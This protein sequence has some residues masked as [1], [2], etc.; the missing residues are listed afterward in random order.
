MKDLY[1]F[2]TSVEDLDDFY[3][4]AI[5]AY[6][7][8][9]ERLSLKVKVVEAA[10]GAFTQEFTHEFQVLN[11]AGEDTVLYCLKCEL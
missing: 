6:K 1:S 4:K 11:D 9:F 8:I 10:G 7:K 5:E 2:H 3:Q